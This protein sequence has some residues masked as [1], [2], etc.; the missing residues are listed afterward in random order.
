M[1]QGVQ[2]GHHFVF[3][4]PSSLVSITYITYIHACKQ[5]LII[6][7]WYLAGSVGTP[8]HSVIKC[9]AIIVDATMDGMTEEEVRLCS[10]W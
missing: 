10:G 5:A 2:F 9:S 3:Y 8:D 1:D 7:A 4:K 6:G